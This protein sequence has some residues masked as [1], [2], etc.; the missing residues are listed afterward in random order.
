[1]NILLGL[2]GFCLVLSWLIPT[3]FLPWASFYNEYAAF[4]ALVLLWLAKAREGKAFSLFLIIGL[5]LIFFI[6]LQYFLGV[7]FFYGDAVM[8]VLYIL[9]ACAAYQIGLSCGDRQALVNSLAWL[10][11]CGGLISALIGIVQWLELGSQWLVTPPYGRSGGN[12]AQPN[13]YASL[14][15][16]S[17]CALSFLYLHQAVTLKTFIFLALVLTFGITVSGS[18]TPLLQSLFFV[19]L[20]VWGVRKG[21]LRLTNAGILL[22][23]L[24]F[25]IWYL[26]FPFIDAWLFFTDVGQL[27]VIERSYSNRIAIWSSLWP[28]ITNSPLLGYGVGHVSV[29]QF[30]FLLDFDRKVEFVEH[31]HNVLM[32][33]VIWFGP[34]FG[35]ALIGILIYWI[36]RQ[37]WRAKTKESWFLL[38]CIGSLVI[39]SL[40]EYPIA[41]AYF[42]LPFSLMLGLL[43]NGSVRS[44][45][46]VGYRY[47]YS[48]TLLVLSTV[49]L[50]QVWKEYRAL[51]ENHR[52]MRAQNLGLIKDQKLQLYGNSR[53]LDGKHEYIL[54]AREKA[55]QGI[56]STRLQ[57]MKK[58]TYRYPHSAA[59]YRYSVALALNG[60]TEEAADELRKIRYYYGDKKY[61]YYKYFFDLSIKEGREM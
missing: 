56:P 25:F 24:L 6:L 2:S 27:G 57:W 28:S 32:D 11:V 55:H 30:T 3:H 22:P 10:L 8:A 21:I 5:A 50:L 7:Y 33:I 20:F 13:N 53:L 46:L 37:L 38:A 41:Y 1:M 43:D 60:R 4:V 18:R 31:S 48:C 9:G 44:V 12:L 58:I 49:I 39:H 35:V 54:F 14:L 52:L 26:S 45:R 42:L 34:L 16:W 15:F 23:V 19:A 40:V 29:A 17:G 47:F 36:G 59:I 51:E 61:E